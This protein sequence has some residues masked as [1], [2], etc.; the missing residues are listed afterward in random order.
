MVVMVEEEVIPPGPPPDPTPEVLEGVYVLDAHLAANK[1]A[2]SRELLSAPGRR[3]AG[4]RYADLRDALRAMATVG[5]SGKLFFVGGRE[6]NGRAHGLVNL[7][8]FLAAAA[9]DSV[10]SGG[11]DEVSADVVDG[12]LPLSNACGQHGR[13]YQDPERCPLYACAPDPTMRAEAG[14]VVQG[15][16]WD[17]DSGD[18]AQGAGYVPPPP[19]KC[20][21]KSD[22]EGGTTGHWDFVSGTEGGLAARNAKG[23]DNVEG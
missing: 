20:G 23:K 4:F 19:F 3:D 5:A 14:T 2:L 18:R 1:I 11:C 12:V 17:G 21:P 9:E 15:D 22:F 6:G 16:W 8:A 10:R 7:A 13:N